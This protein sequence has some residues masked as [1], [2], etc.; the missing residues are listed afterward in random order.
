[1]F[2]H[3]SWHRRT[4][5]RNKISCL[6]GEGN[7]LPNPY[8]GGNFEKIIYSVFTD[9]C[10]AYRVDRMQQGRIKRAYDILRSSR[11]GNSDIS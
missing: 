8:K 3:L 7:Q 2:Y 9:R 4:R 6:P 1:M 5:V 11:V 10:N